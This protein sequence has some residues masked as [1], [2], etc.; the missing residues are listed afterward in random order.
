MVVN[1]ICQVERS[2]GSVQRGWFFGPR[3]DDPRSDLDVA[4]T[5]SCDASADERPS[6]RPESGTAT[7]DRPAA[8]RRM[9]GRVRTSG[10]RRPERPF[11]RRHPQADWDTSAHT[12]DS[13]R[14][15]GPTRPD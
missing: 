4:S 15:S 3:A 7:I 8:H 5:T 1:L 2:Q 12:H 13:T 14:R 6:P 9:T 10:A 11:G